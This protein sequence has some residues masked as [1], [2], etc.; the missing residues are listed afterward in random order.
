VVT[1]YPGATATPMMES[2]QAGDELGFGR[3]GADE[4]ADEIIEGIEHDLIEINTALPTRR[5]LQ[6]LNRTDPTAV[7]QT[8]AL[9]LPRC[10]EPC[11]GTAPSDP[12]V[13]RRRA[14]IMALLPQIALSGHTVPFLGSLPCDNRQA[15]INHEVVARDEGGVIGC[16]EQHGRGDLL[17]SCHSPQDP[18]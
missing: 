9:C 2:N 12:P 16:E 5:R 14:A 15:A 18:I 11:P 17:R 1:A 10:G 3:R 7:D 6:E 4:V 8:L 13:T